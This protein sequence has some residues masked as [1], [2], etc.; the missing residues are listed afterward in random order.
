M[1]KKPTPAISVGGTLSPGLRRYLYFTAIITGAV[2][3]IVEILGA[4]ML[5]PYVGTSHFVWTAQIAVTLLSLATG[6]SFGGWLVDRSQRLSRLYTCVLFAAIYL[7][8]TV[9]IC[10]PIAYWCLRF[11][12]AVGSVLASLFLFFVPLTLL[13]AVGPFLIRVL[14]QSVNVAGSQAG[15]LS[16]VS[17]FGSVLGTIL[18]GYVLIPYLPNSITMYATAGILMVV[19]V[20]YFVVWGKKD[21]E[22]GGIITGIVFA[23]LI[24]YLGIHR[25]NHLKLDH[26]SQIYRHNSNFGLLQ[27][28]RDDDSGILYYLN[29]YLTQN[30]YD[31]AA[32][33]SVHLFTYMLHGLAHAYAPKTQ[34]VLCIGLGVGI[35]PMRFANEGAKV[36]VVEINPAIIPVA[37]KYFDLQPEKLNITV[38]DGRYYLNETKKQYDVVVLDAFLGDASPSHL[39]TREAFTGI[40][41]VLKPEGVLVI[42]SFGDFENGK[43][44]LTTSL[45]KTLKAVFPSVRIHHSGNGNVFFVASN[46]SALKVLQLPDFSEVHPLVE[47][48]VEAAFEG[49]ATTNPE[50]GIILTDNYNPSDFYDAQ[51]R[52]RL[53]RALAMN[54]RRADVEE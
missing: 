3:L 15:R 46:L 19:T 6:Y 13:A 4:K 20:I 27:V 52:E 34:A 53:R 40:R 37:A 1:K 22:L 47:G 50:H 25:E 44:F 29:D 36:D 17:T 2:V 26:R 16:S 11:N 54:M 7:A 39:M 10:E 31:P 5:S 48:R 23:L 33:K 38:G 9:A 32:K 41:K 30:G 18:I 43:D 51:N 14:I 35:V 49:V 45:D 24:G 21:H 42:N 8:L 28:V 12:L